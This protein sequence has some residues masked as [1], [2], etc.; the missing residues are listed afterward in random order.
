MK[1]FVD[2]NMYLC[3]CYERKKMI[4]IQVGFKMSIKHMPKWKVKTKNIIVF[5]SPTNKQITYLNCIQQS[6]KKP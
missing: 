1:V 4:C 3:V 6:K 2:G 5:E